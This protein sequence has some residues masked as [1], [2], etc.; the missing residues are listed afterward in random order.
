RRIRKLADAE[1]IY[2]HPILA[3]IP[4]TAKPVP[5]SGGVA[6]LPDSVREQFRKLRM[7]LLLSGIEAPPRTIVVTSAVP[8]EGK[9]TVT[10]NLA[11]AYREAGLK[12]CV[13]D[14]DLRRPGLSQLLDVPVAP[15]LTD[16]V[17]GDESLSG[18]L[19]YLAVGVPGLKTLH[20]LQSGIS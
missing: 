2:A 17:V 5:I 14:G 18:A 19:K 15:G 4:R 8:R 1:R 13:I 10:R 7:S 6:V 12:V 9:S 11:L 3:A 20:R 16:V